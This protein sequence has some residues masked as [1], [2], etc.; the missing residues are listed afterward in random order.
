MVKKFKWYT[1][2]IGII[3]K[4]TLIEADYFISIAEYY[5]RLLYLVYF[6]I[7]NKILNI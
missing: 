4:N 5:Y 2:N 3:V 1:T 7:I 6:I